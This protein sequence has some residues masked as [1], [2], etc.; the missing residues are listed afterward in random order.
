MCASCAPSA[1]APQEPHEES[2]EDSKGP[3]LSKAALARLLVEHVEGYA[4][5]HT[6]KT[7]TSTT[8]T[9]TTPGT[10]HSVMVMLCGVCTGGGSLSKAP[11]CAK[12]AHA[13]LHLRDH[14]PSIDTQVLSTRQASPPL[15]LQG[16]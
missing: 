14:D 11:V 12:A 9:H 4:N 8:S 5:I 16:I 3:Y 2:E 10:V 6:G 15:A 13:L 1:A 7:T